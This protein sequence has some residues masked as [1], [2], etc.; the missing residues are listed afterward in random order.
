[1]RFTASRPYPFSYYATN[2]SLPFS[3]GSAWKWIADEDISLFLFVPAYLRHRALES[4][5]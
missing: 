5:S 1:M 2:S 3:L 4:L